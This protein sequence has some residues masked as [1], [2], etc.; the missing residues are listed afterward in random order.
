M[1]RR[2]LLTAAPAV[3]VLAGAAIA[4]AAAASPSAILDAAHQIA[5]LGREYDKADM[6]GVDWQTLDVIWQKVWAH[7]RV[8]LDA[9]PVTVLEATVIVM[10]AA[11]KLDLASGNDDNGEMVNRA[12]RAT[13]RATRFLAGTAG[14]TVEDIGGGV[15]LPE[16]DGA[17]S[18]GRAA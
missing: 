14:V 10:V 7:E 12:T 1:K 5:A 16:S 17:A 8:I 18:M 11:G 13:A 15:Y 9:T 6:V 4:P 3:A 2:S